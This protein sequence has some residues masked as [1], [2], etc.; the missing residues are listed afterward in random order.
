MQIKSNNGLIF[1][2]RGFKLKSF[3]RFLM[4][5]LIS[6]APLPFDSQTIFWT[7][8]E[9]DLTKRLNYTVEVLFLPVIIV[10][11]Y[12]NNLRSQVTSGNYVL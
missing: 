7:T 1:T 8:F 11:S 2:T 10:F 3:L 4:L 12:W 9:E 5:L 6:M